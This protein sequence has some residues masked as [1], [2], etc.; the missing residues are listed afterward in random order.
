MGTNNRN[1]YGMVRGVPLAKLKPTRNASVLANRLSPLVASMFVEV[2]STTTLAE[3][4]AVL[5]TGD[6]RIASKRTG[7]RNPTG[8]R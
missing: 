8:P 5:R 7:P 2:L 4:P 3:P 1:V 6:P